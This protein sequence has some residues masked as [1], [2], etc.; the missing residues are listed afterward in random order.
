MS[1][2]R[3]TWSVVVGG[4]LVVFGAAVGIAKF[5]SLM[6]EAEA[7]VKA[8]ADAY[9]APILSAKDICERTMLDDTGMDPASREVTTYSVNKL[10]TGH[11]VRGSVRDYRGKTVLLTC[12]VGPDGVAKLR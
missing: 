1:E 6:R 3:S 8:R 2:A 7:D 9:Y 5:S 4:A 11:E 10:G 12:F